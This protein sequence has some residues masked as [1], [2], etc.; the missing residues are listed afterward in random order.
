M[1]EQNNKKTIYFVRHGESTANAGGLRQGAN[2]V[3]TDKGFKQAEFIAKRLKNLPIEVLISST[4]LRAKQT[5]EVIGQ[6]SGHEIIFSD[7]LVERRNPSRSINKHIDDP[8]WKEIFEDIWKNYNNPDWRFEDAEN[9]VDLLQRAK[10]ALDF[11]LARPES[12]IVVVTHGLFLKVILTQILSGGKSSLE[13]IN[14]L[15]SSFRVDNTGVSIV[16]YDNSAEDL[17]RWVVR[18]WNDVAHLDDLN[19][20]ELPE[21][22]K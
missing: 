11:I 22:Q 21:A 18:T 13:L 17:F 15:L 10:E 6:A 5:A 9:G 20:D 4:Y 14:N 3:L 16:E 2:S 1:T 8:E 12:R 7:L 19:G